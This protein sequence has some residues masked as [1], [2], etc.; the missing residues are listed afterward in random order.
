M[1][2]G[3]HICP[4]TETICKCFNYYISS[5]LPLGRHTHA[6]ISTLLVKLALPNP[7]AQFP[8]LSI[9]TASVQKRPPKCFTVLLRQSSEESK[10]TEKRNKGFA[11]VNAKMD[12]QERIHMK[13]KTN[14]YSHARAHTERE[15]QSA[16]IQEQDTLL[17][18]SGQVVYG[19]VPA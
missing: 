18:V 13:Q 3:A 1:W 2:Q 4:L 9:L 7:V 6:H 12:L 5:L 16:F 17:S 19:L 10:G 11:H 14:P 8:T 15:N